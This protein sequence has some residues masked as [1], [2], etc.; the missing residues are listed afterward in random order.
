ML[1]VVRGIAWVLAGLV[2]AGF[3]LVLAGPYEEVDTRIDFDPSTMPSDLDGWLADRESQVPDLREDEA[4]RVLWAGA[5]GR[6][7]EWAVVYVHGFSAGIWETRPLAD[8]VAERLGANLHFT[9]LT[10]HGRDGAALARAS[11]GDWL[12]DMAEAMAVG[13]ALGERVLVIATSQGGTLAAVAAADPALAGIRDGMEGLVLISPN[14]RV[15]N[16]AARLLSWPAARAWVPLV[17]GETRSWEPFND[18]HAR[19]WTTSY[20]TVATLPVQALIDHADGLDWSRA[21]VP[22]LFYYDPADQVVDASVTARVA[23]GWGGPVTVAEVATPEGDDPLAH[24]IAGDI[25]SPAGTPMAI[26]AIVDWAGGL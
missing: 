18:R 8:R 11:A 20:P 7:T 6:R 26:D 23:N 4:K 12:E 5:V 19:H 13:R 3:A 1:T 15:A 14:F 10:G 16:P 22:A 2:I 24:V 17:A 21:T 9:R 25:L